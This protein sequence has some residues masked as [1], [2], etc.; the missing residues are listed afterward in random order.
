[1]FFSL[2]QR[3]NAKSGKKIKITGEVV[4]KDS[5]QPLEFATL[6]LQNANDPN[7]VTGGISDLTVNFRFCPCWQV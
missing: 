2:R 3:P 6:V 5:G 7:Q 4:D 1:M